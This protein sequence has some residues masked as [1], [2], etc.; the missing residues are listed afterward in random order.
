LNIKKAIL[1][2][3]LFVAFFY[4]AKWLFGGGA[5]GALMITILIYIH[6]VGHALAMK[7]RKIACNG[8][9]LLPFLGAMTSMDKKDVHSYK[10]EAIVAL[11]GPFTGIVMSV[12]LYLAAT[13][14]GNEFYVGAMGLVAL[15]NLV[16]LFPSLPLDGGRI[17]YAL[18]SSLIEDAEGRKKLANFGTALTGLV[19]ILS[20][21]LLIPVVALI[22]F[23]GIRSLAQTEERI[24][25]KVER[26]SYLEW[27]IDSEK[28]WLY[29]DQVKIETM[30]QEMRRLDDWLKENPVMDKMTRPEAIRMAIAWMAVSSGLSL[31]CLWAYLIVGWD[32]LKIMTTG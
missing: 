22:G 2:L 20:G 9:Y 12:L 16:N 28:E 10:D 24:K 27:Q 15:F 6:E 25:M 29:P 14:T 4:S 13:I 8:I 31:C 3:V 23:M 18:I 26:R 32:F 17:A 5:A 21:F 19:G 1:K 7:M 30:Q 11:L